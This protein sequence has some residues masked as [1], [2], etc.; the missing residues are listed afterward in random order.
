MA[1]LHGFHEHRVQDSIVLHLHFVFLFSPPI[2]QDGKTWTY[3]FISLC[4][5]S[6]P[7]KK[8]NN[9]TSALPVSICLCSVIKLFRADCFILCICIALGIGEL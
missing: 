6:P 9:D 3:C 5:T 8:R 1:G 2:N 4:F 7:I